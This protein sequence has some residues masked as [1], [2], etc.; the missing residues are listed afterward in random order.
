MSLLV[1]AP[2]PDDETL[3]CGATLLRKIAEGVDVHW[4]IVTGMSEQ[5]GYGPER[6]ATRRKEI[7]AVASAYGFA[8]TTELGLPPGGLDTVPTRTLVAAI[9][10]VVERI[11][12]T[13]LLI[14]WRG[15]AHSDHR[16]VFDAATTCA[17]RF[18]HP[19][20]RRV[21]AY[22]T[23]SETDQGL[24]PTAAFIPT[25]FADVTGY[26]DRQVE[27]LR[28]YEGEI[29]AHPFPRSEDG[30]RALATV[31]GAAVAADAAEAFV[32]L[33]ELA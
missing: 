5:S 31:R 6:I 19:F 16:T 29:G 17:K 2:H 30:V 12:P 1:I 25:S 33:R 11:Q 15:D 14:P 28:L 23:P 21:L 3:G 22:E 24:D 20:V 8:S 13:E 18:R 32:L 4:L 26:V 27:I 7:D 9:G 10:E